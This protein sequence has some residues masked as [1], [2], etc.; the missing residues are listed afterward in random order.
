MSSD[1][2]VSG[3]TS[4]AGFA[5]QMRIFIYLLSKIDKTTQVEFE[6]IEDVAINNTN[7]TDYF[8][9][10]TELF[11]SIIDKSHRYT[12]YQ[13]KR[14]DITN[15]VVDKVVLNWLMLESKKQ[16]LIEK[17]VLITDGRSDDILSL[18]D[19]DPKVVFQNVQSSDKRSDAIIS[20]VKQHYQGN[21]KNFETDYLEIKKKHTIEKIN[22]IDDL[23]FSD[24]SSFFHKEGVNDIIYSFRIKQLITIIQSEILQS[25]NNKHPY[26]CT[27]ASLM[28]IIEIITQDIR[29]E[30]ITLDYVAFRNFVK[31]NLDDSTVTSSREYKQLKSC[32]LSPSRI[33][34]HLVFCQYY[35]NLK[36]QY[37]S[38]MQTSKIS[39]LE[40]T[41]ITNF[42]DS[43][44]YLIA[45]NNDSPYIR[46]DETKRRNNFYAPKE[47]VKFGSCIYLT[48]ENGGD[49]IISWDDTI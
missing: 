27:Y 37:L 12:A 14:S 28:K 46:L 45:N 31:V 10:N 17:Y 20:K 4:L 34:E 36:M 44:E 2:S 9:K 30:E 25:V 19:R 39:N 21:Y 24:Y 29:N 38:S 32:G 40:N 47:Q 18:F 15:G 3:I 23:I 8:D 6:T 26:I 49:P 13:V 43:K 35:Q 7:T 41:T 1:A 16:R 11:S 48:K 42:L 5:F 33:E 22:N